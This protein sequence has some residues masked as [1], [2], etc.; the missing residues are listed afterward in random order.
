MR[1]LKFSPSFYRTVVLIGLV[2]LPWSKEAW[3]SPALTTALNQHMEHPFFQE[4]DVGIQVVNANTKEEVF[5][6]NSETHLIPASVM[7]SLTAAV[8]LKEL[9]TEY[10]F[11]TDIRYTGEIND[12]GVLKG[13]LYVVGGGD[14]YMDGEGIW[15]LIRDMKVEGINSIHGGIY[16]DDSRYDGASFIP[17]WGKEVDLANG[18][19]YFPMRSSL[20]FN[21]NNVAIHVRPGSRVGSKA[22][23]F[24]EYPYSIVEIDNQVKT[25]SPGSNSW[26][27]VEREVIF[28]DKSQ[29][30][31]EGQ[32]QNV[33]KILYHF[34]GRIPINVQKDWVYYRSILE[35][36]RFFKENFLEILVQ[37]GVGHRG[38][39]GFQTVPDH[40]QTLVSHRSDPL[41]SL[42]GDMNKYSRNLTAEALILEMAAQKALPA[43]T[44]QG[45]ASVEGYLERLGVWSEGT[46][47]YNGSGLSPTMQLQASQVSA[48]MLDMFDNQLIGP[49]YYTSL[50]VAGRDGTLRRRLQEEQYNAR[51]RGKTGSINGVYCLATYVLGGDGNTYVVVFFVNN[52]RRRTSFVR[53]LQNQFLQTIIDT[54][55]TVF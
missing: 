20:S 23:V 31:T 26:M 6:Y 13:N 32:Y 36:E 47:L 54:P 8:A 53:E 10:R 9:G 41:R 38:R 50:A 1:T 7:K 2:L 24:L 55:S 45:L 12:E 27:S 5:S 25:S 3:A 15:K 17:G 39:S 28:E 48:V 19:S 42:I 14:P 46:V 52:L 21:T 40:A 37:H 18:P 33:E 4:S 22:K 35:P 16:F 49:E 11:V 30:V 43:T 29:E 51:A 34:T 44:A